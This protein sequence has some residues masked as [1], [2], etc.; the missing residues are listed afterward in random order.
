MTK[1]LRFG[2]KAQ[3]CLKSKDSALDASDHR[4]GGD[5]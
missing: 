4:S 5:R 1:T 3:V 2:V